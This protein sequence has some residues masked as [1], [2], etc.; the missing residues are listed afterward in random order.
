MQELTAFQRDML[1]VIGGLDAPKG[2]EVKEHLGS[3][4]ESAINHGRLYPNL[5]RL[6]DRGLVAKGEKDGRSN[7]YSL[8]EWGERA[9]VARREWETAC[10]SP[11]AWAP[12]AESP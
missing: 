4:Y 10:V 1:V 7:E 6:V 11:T 2:L 5:D 8:T 12:E 9:L 3:Y